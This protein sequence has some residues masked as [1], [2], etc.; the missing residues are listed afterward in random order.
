MLGDSFAKNTSA[1][2]TGVHNGDPEIHDP[3][4]ERAVCSAI[5]RGLDSDSR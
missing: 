4:R 2:H 3:K 1:V 5:P